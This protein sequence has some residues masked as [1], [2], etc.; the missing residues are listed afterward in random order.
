MS[1]NCVIVMEYMYFGCGL[2]A[3][4]IVN[5]SVFSIRGIEQV[6]MLFPTCVFS[7]I[8]KKS[9]FSLQILDGPN[10]WILDLMD[11]GSRKMGF[12]FSENL[13]KLKK[14]KFHPGTI[15]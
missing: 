11:F 7:E 6:E 10:F 4:R 9:H 8:K 15:L 14:T 3:Q 1:T 13:N 12:T 5:I 2:A